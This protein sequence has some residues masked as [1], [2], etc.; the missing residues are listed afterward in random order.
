[1]AQ[2]VADLLGR[3]DVTEA[4]ERIRP[5]V[6]QTPL[7]ES[8]AASRLAGGSVYLK[9][10]T[11][12]PTGSFK[13]RGAANKIASISPSCLAR[14]VITASTGNHGRATAYIARRVGVPCTVCLS[15][16]VP[17][18]KVAAI[19]SLGSEVDLSGDDQ[20]DAVKR[21]MRLAEEDGL[22]F[23][24]PFDD[25]MVI[26]GQGT[27]GLELVA[28]L[29]DLKT[30][31]IPLSGGGLAAGVALAVKTSHPHVKIV[32]V[33]SDRCPAMMRSIEAGCPITV[34]ERPSLMDSL[35]GGIGLENEFT[36][37]LVRDLVDQIHL[38]S[39]EQV[40]V[41]IRFAFVEER[42]V[43][44]GAAAAPIALVLGLGAGSL[45]P[46]IA[47]LVTGANIDDRLFLS[48]IRD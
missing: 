33:S 23:V 9:I 15:R 37:R 2:E 17:N 35:G 4:A 10:E 29:P 40:A 12:Q 1:M 41:A 39:D 14:G 48:V 38:V 30:I 20:D 24:P 18:N 26:A 13:V 47:A 42:L 3:E 19:R 7:R 22:V 32:G 43:L 5:F 27:I 11:V 16:L 46:P 34:E 36:F 6:C 25:P 45:E 21:A 44:E 8:L 28:A 31:V